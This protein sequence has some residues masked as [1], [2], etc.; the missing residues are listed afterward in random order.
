MPEDRLPSFVIIGAAKSA[1]TWLAHNLQ[2]HPQVFVPSVEVH[3]FSRHYVMGVS[4]Y[5]AH[6]KGARV[7]QVVGERSNTYFTCPEAPKRLRNLLPDVRLI[8]QLRNPIERAYSDYCMHLRR[9]T[10]SSEIDIYFDISKTPMPHLLNTGLYYYNLSRFLDEF[11]G[12]RIEVLLCDDIAAEPALSFKRACAFIGVHGDSPRCSAGERVNGNEVPEVNPRLR[13]ML[14]PLQWLGAP[15][16]AYRHQPWFRRLRSCL[17]S[18]P[19]YPPLSTTTR[20]RLCA[21]YRDD[22]DALSSI[23]G[24]DLRSWLDPAASGNAAQYPGRGRP[25][26]TQ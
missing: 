5:A 18:L 23:L 7:G 10:V 3:Y 4:W 9:R 8:V 20:D 11:P 19:P 24:R 1:T 12:D 6:F 21:F 22:V 25:S 2:R 26:P 15:H 13:G 14:R 17:G 16:A